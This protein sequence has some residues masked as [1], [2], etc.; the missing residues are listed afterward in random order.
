MKPHYSVPIKDLLRLTIGRAADAVLP[1][2]TRF[3]VLT[4]GRSGSNFLTSLMKSHRSIIQH[5]EI[6]GEF[7]LGSIR[8]Q[9][10]I[11]RV[12]VTSY[13]DQRLG[14]MAFETATG[15]KILYGN[16]EPGYGDQHGIPGIEAL[17]G[18]IANDPTLRIIHLVRK[19]KLAMLI[20]TQLAN[21]TQTWLA[22]NYDGESVTLPVDWVRSQFEWLETWENWVATTIPQV[23]VFNTTYEALVARNSDEVDRVFDFLGVPPAPVT[24]PMKKQLRRP[25]CEVVEN[26]DALCEAFQGTRYAELFAE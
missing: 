3:V 8:V 7:Q 5:G 13:L 26:Y 16:L 20:S 11:N 9:H 24:S 10:R 21:K 4:S 15:V 1:K 2:T 17:S 6:F 19:D 14:R 18:H 25:K 12:G 23:R 22:G